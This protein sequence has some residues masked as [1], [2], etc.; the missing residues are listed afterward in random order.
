MPSKAIKVLLIDDDEGMERIVRGWLRTVEEMELDLLWAG[1]LEQGF[2]LLSRQAVDLILL[3]LNL[4]DSAGLDTVVQTCQAAPALPIIVL[5]ANDE[6]EVGIEAVKVGAQDY[7]LKGDVNVQQLRRS[8]VF[9]IERKKTELEILSGKEKLKQEYE[10]IAQATQKLIS[11]EV[12]SRLVMG[13]HGKPLK[14]EQLL[15]TIMFADI[16]GF[17][18][19]AEH[20]PA[21][22]VVKVLNHLMGEMVISVMEEGGYL[23]KFLGDGLM[24]VF[25]APRT[26]DNQWLQAA[27]AAFKMQARVNLFNRRRLKL[28]PQ[29]ADFDSDLQIGIGLHSG[30]AI[31]GF[32]GTHE[33][34]EYTAI[35]DCV[36]IA[37]RLCMNAKG[38]EILI[39]RVI[40]DGIRE[41]GELENWRL[42]QV[43]GKALNIEVATL[44][45]VR[46]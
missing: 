3:D 46:L 22:E 6:G 40:A 34:C 1:S 41:Q 2:N 35:G 28:F 42:L 36:N 26:L 43:K 15:V 39:T 23:D 20:Y 10:D 27:R 45:S 4:P 9:A 29:L 8:I 25:G 18:A 12:V 44:R 33:R 31:V 17:S 38:G 37:S 30:T 11:P 32:I 14:S 13:D 16:R 21:E 5:T 19:F 7:L 24:A